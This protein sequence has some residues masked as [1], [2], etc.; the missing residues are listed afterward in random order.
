M[1]ANKKNKDRYTKKKNVLVT[2][3][4]AK[5]GCLY[6]VDIWAWKEGLEMERL[7]RKISKMAMGLNTNKPDYIRTEAGIRSMGIEA[8][9]RAGRYLIRI[10]KISKER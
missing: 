8:R 7:K 5:A 1:G 10:L 2:N 4:L 6:G 9:K 3:A